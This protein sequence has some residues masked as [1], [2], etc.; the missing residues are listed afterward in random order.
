MEEPTGGTIK[1][2]QRADG[3]LEAKGLHSS[4]ELDWSSVITMNLEPKNIG[5]GRYQHLVPTDY[6]SQE[7][8]FIPETHSLHVVTT[9]IS[10]GKHSC[11]VHHWK[12]PIK[13][14]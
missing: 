2:T 13:R 12:R 8:T 3:L 5:T 1:I 7:I 11:F 6:G 9:N 4:G 14:W 10:G